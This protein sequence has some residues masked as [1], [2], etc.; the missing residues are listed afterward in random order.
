VNDEKDGRD[1]P[2]AALFWGPEAKQRA[3]DY[4][5]WQN[6]QLATTGEQLLRR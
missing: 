1:E 3:E 2:C 6:R 4:A 5:E